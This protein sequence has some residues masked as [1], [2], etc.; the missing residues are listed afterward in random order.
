MWPQ[1]EPSREEYAEALENLKKAGNSVDYIITHT[2]PEKVR[3][4]AF[5]VYD[6]FIEYSS[7]VEQFLDIVYDNVSYKKWFAGHI[8]IDRE[9]R[10]HRLRILY[11]SIVKI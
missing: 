10:E 3:K 7:G 6:D 5:S 11:N 8:H 2:C 9:F 1:E 4:Q